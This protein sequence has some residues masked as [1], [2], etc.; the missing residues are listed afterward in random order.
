[1]HTT[2][3]EKKFSFKYIIVLEFFNMGVSELIKGFDPSPFSDFITGSTERTTYKGF[4]SQWYRV[5]GMSICLTMI[6]SALFTNITEAARI[7]KIFV[8]R[9]KDRSFKLNI[10]KNQEDSDDDEVNTKQLTQDDLET[11]YT[12]EKFEGDKSISRMTS[13]LLVCLA[14][15]SGMPIL[16]FIAFAFFF[17]TYLTN[18]V[19]LMQYYQKTNT[20]NRVV[21]MYSVYKFKIGIFFHMYFG[22]FMMTNPSIFETKEE[23]SHSSDDLNANIP[24]ESFYYQRV[25]FAHQKLYIGFVVLATVCYF[26]QSFLISVF[27][28]L[29]DLAKSLYGFFDSKVLVKI[30]N[31]ISK[32]QKK[33]CLKVYTFA[34]N[35]NRDKLEKKKSSDK[36]LSS[37][38][39]I[40]RN[41]VVDQ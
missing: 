5:I 11:L 3:Q 35:Y 29:R 34:K 8:K 41:K 2:I 40:D 23:F 6:Q 31:V 33:L 13:T 22:I 16:Y 26:F 7:S 1:M 12:G 10:K 17:I 21:P 37:I 14:F 39:K 28:I 4:E 20:L 19:M 18:K 25:K 38:D 24:Q 36:S 27:K 30:C 32:Y 15:S 9:L